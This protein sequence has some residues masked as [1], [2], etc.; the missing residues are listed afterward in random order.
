MNMMRVLMMGYDRGYDGACE[1]RYIMYDGYM[2]N[3]I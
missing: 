1:D 2:R 3:I